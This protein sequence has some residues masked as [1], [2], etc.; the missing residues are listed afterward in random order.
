MKVYVDGTK[1]KTYSE[2]KRTYY[3]FVDWT[4]PTLTS[5][6]VMG[7]N[8][9]A[10]YANTSYDSSA[11]DVYQAFYPNTSYVSC[12]L[13][14]K[15]S[16]MYIY[17]QS[18]NY[19]LITYF[20]FYIPILSS[21]NDLNGGYANN[22]K[23]EGFNIKNRKWETLATITSGSNMGNK[24]HTMSLSSNTKYYKMFRLQGTT[25][26]GGHC[27]RLDII[28]IKITAKQAIES[29]SNDYN[30]YENKYVYKGVI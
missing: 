15:S 7:V 26:G 11:I 13:S 8:D 6:G 3:K 16:T 14:L 4:Q 30:F 24:T 28:Q 10:C 20:S 5:N 27:D 12:Y 23:L 19:L 18:K 29:A 21:A 22:L 25:G 17:F 9:F 2:V 1:Y